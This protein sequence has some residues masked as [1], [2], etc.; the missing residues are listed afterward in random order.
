MREII[1]H[2]SNAGGLPALLD[3]V[4][5]DRMFGLRT[6]ASDAGMDRRGLASPPRSPLHHRATRTPADELPGREESRYYLTMR[7]QPIY[8]SHFRPL[9]KY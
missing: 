4:R 1:R 2:V 5:N 8:L 3:P 9:V 7:A 6:S